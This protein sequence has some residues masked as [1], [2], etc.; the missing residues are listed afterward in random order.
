MSDFKIRLVEKRRLA[1]ILFLADESDLRMSTSL[2]QMALESSLFKVNSDDVTQDIDFL[3]KCGLAT[4]EHIGHLP[5]VKLTE[6]GREAAKGT[7]K[8]L[9]VQAP[10]LD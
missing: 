6:A 10:P 9:G 3:R 1:I 2:L 4:L 5:A 8:V 7:R